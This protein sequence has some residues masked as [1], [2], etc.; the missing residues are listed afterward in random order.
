[1]LCRIT[2]NDRVRPVSEMLVGFESSILSGPMTGVANYTFNIV[3]CA[4]ELDPEV[5]FSGFQ[6]R[7]WRRFDLGAAQEIAQRK[8][9]DS[10]G[11]LSA[12][13]RVRRRMRDRAAQIPG[14]RGAAAIYRETRRKK[15]VSSVHSQSLDLFHAFNFRPLTDPGIP[16]LPVIYD[17]STFRHPEFHP[18]DRVRWLEP[19]RQ[20]IERAP[21]VQ[22]ISDF[23]RREIASLF[24]YPM[25]QILVV[26][27]AAAALFAP[28]GETTT[29]PG[30]DALGLKYGQFFL[31]VGTH[32]PRKNIRTVIQA[33]SRLTPSE[34]ARCPLVLAGGRGWGNL[35]LPEQTET[36]V[37]DGSVR[38]VHDVTDPQ[39]RNL[40]EGARLLLAPSLYEGFGMPVVEALACGTPV[41]YSADTAMEEISGDTGSRVGALDVDGWTGV[42]KNALNSTDHADPARRTERIARAQEFDWRRSAGLVLDAYRRILN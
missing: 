26:P 42:L 13:A 4:L 10:D 18:G 1:M 7:D 37:R 32:E 15:F 21:L 29:Q 24:G 16:V 22:T 40:Y 25:A 19:L 35:D 8:Q 17:L 6:G 23:S 33:Y 5:G 2:P 28:L 39:L 31:V 20:T 14:L 30:L 41:A 38:F 27:P 12:Y 36:L 11:R 34:R 9:T 3:R